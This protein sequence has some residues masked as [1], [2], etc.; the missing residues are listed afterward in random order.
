MPAVE[1]YD[2]TLRDGAQQ[3][4]IALSV[5]DKIAIAERLDD[6]GIH[7]IE[8][9]YAGANPKED[10]FF[11]Q[12][13]QLRLKESIVTVF[14][15]TRRAGGEVSRDSIIRALLDSETLVVTLVGKSSDMHV[16]RVLETS[17]EENLSMI[18]ES[19]E[20]LLKRERRV[21]FDAEHFFDGYIA[22]PDYALQTV[23]VAA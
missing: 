22:N 14:G 9:G 13:R 5:D 7:Y 11:R 3:Q 12:A 16:A 17:P 15:N 1:L 18:A 19:V 21:F 2:T 10:E 6:L 20:Y 23:R 8:G 4:G